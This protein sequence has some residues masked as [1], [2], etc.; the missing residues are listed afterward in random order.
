VNYTIGDSGFF[1]TDVS[2]INGIDNRICMNVKNDSPN[3]LRKMSDRTIWD[4]CMDFERIPN[5]RRKD[6]Q[7]LGNN[8]IVCVCASP[9]NS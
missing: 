7:I 9:E 1:T 3:V 6:F 4:L 8:H 2:H 5:T